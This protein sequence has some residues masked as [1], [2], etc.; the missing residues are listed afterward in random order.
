MQEVNRSRR[1][2]HTDALLINTFPIPEVK[3]QGLFVP[4]QRLDMLDKY[5]A[6]EGGRKVRLSRA[7]RLSN[8]KQDWSGS[9]RLMA[10]VCWTPSQ[11]A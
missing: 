4:A 6:A 3:A 11:S 9:I 5:A 1:R 7:E 2:R 8:S 10:P